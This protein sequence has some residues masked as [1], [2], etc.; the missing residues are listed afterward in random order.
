MQILLNIYAYLTLFDITIL[1]FASSCT[2]SRG[3]RNLVAVGA[4]KTPPHNTEKPL[5]K[6]RKNDRNGGDDR[7]RV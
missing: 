7:A 3:M 4:T 2:A 5:S 6:K 1:L